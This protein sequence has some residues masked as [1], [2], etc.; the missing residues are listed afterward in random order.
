M[1]FFSMGI[2]I[3]GCFHLSQIIEHFGPRIEEVEFTKSYIA[4]T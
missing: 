2:F 1:F 3:H 4:V